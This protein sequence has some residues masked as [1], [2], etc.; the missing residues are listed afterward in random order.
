MRGNEMHFY[1]SQLVAMKR[2][3]MLKINAVTQKSWMKGSSWGIVGS[4]DVEGVENLRK[5]PHD[6]TSP[7]SVTQ[8]I[9]VSVFPH[10]KIPIHAQSQTPYFSFLHHSNAPYLSPTGPFRSKPSQSVN[11][12]GGGDLREAQ[13][14]V[15]LSVS[16]SCVWPNRC[17]L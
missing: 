3:I 11:W 16:H 4:K 12:G 7:S 15:P 10:S 6:S 5:H 9:Q 13:G 8:H 1:G 2:S 17:A 14:D